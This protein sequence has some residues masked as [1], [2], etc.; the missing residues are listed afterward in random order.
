MSMELNAAARLLERTMPGLGRI[1]P[2][3]S[4]CSGLAMAPAIVKGAEVLVAVG[5][6]DGVIPE[7]LGAAP[8]RVSMLSSPSATGFMPRP[9]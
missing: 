5:V 7:E 8:V 1:T 3:T 6:G 9:L 4:L 2:P